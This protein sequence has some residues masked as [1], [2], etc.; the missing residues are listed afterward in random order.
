MIIFKSDE[1]IEKMY[2]IGQITCKILLYLEENISD[3]IS[4]LEIDSMARQKAGEAHAYPAFLG[5]YG[6]PKAI[7]VS[8]NEEV[9]HGI[10]SK[11]VIIRKGD[12]V[13]LDFGLFYDGFYSDMART[14]IVGKTDAVGTKLNEVTKECLNY[15]IEQAVA[16]NH[17]SDISV[18]VE[19]HAL[20]NKFSVV[21]DYVG[22]G[23]GKELHEDPQVPNYYTGRTGDE[24]AA[25][26][27]L[28]IEPMITEGKS[29]VFVKRNHWTVATRD[30]KR[31]S[32]FED[33]IAITRKG[34][35]ILTRV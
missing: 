3:G 33:S 34:V 2:K 11:R 7:C 5:Y 30:H 1:E 14:F 19:N 31:S 15:G 8:I 24:I 35:R 29:D 20:N 17:I 22:H 6:F 28:A 25:G 12:L 27:T 23:V 18:A 21:K 16:G 9:V 13:S 4:S 26:M 32:H 10:P